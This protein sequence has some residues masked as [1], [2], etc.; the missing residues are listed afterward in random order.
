MAGVDS[1]AVGAIGSVLQA[2]MGVGGSELHRNGF[3][4]LSGVEKGNFT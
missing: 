4:V 1:E 2:C 3:N